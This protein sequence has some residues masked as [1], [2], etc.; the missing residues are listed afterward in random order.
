M[1]LTRIARQST[2]ATRI[3]ARP[4]EPPALGRQVRIR[5]RGK[6]GARFRTGDIET[7]DPRRGILQCRAF[8]Q[9]NHVEKPLMIAFGHAGADHHEAVITCPRDGEVAG[10]PATHADQRRQA[11]TANLHR[12]MIRDQ[13]VEP[14]M[15]TRHPR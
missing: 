15:G 11:G 6:Q 8:R 7:G 14:A 4:H 13:R 10:N 12:N 5:Q 1:K 2:P 9:W 3:V